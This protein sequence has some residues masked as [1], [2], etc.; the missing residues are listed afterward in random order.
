[1]C[2]HRS[3]LTNGA[4]YPGR[5]LGFAGATLNTRYNLPDRAIAADGDSLDDLLVP[6]WP[7]HTGQEYRSVT[8][9]RTR[10]TFSPSL[11]PTP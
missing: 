10:P 2:P 8:V 4:A 11:P 1:M 9:R 3:G 6:D 7:V 5:R